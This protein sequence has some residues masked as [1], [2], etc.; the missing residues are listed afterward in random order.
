MRSLKAELRELY[1]SADEVDRQAI[2]SALEKLEI[3]DV[4]DFDVENLGEELSTK[5]KEFKNDSE[6]ED[7]TG[8]D[9]SAMINGFLDER[10]ENR[11]NRN[12]NENEVE[13]Q[14][15]EQSNN[16]NQVAQENKNNAKNKDKG[17]SNKGK[18]KGK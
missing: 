15:Q 12:E 1:D 18:A 6:N 4:E 17:K 7:W 9:L 11:K 13:V 14:N 16:Q 8:Q 10:I 2:I 5:I 3:E